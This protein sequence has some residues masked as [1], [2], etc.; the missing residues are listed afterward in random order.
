MHLF[1]IR[2]VLIAFAIATAASASA[3]AADPVVS[4]ASAPADAAFY[5]ASLR[6]GEQWDRFHKSKAFAALHDLP[7]LK[8]LFQHLNDE[9]E[10]PGS[11]VGR[12]SSSTAGATGWTS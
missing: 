3:R 7:A 1:S 5:S 12:R 6:L 8:H 11:P 2:R 10:K 4:L 9:I